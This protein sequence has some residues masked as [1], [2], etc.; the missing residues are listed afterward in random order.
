VTIITVGF[1]T[2]LSALLRSQADQYSPL[3]G[4]ELVQKKVN[5][6]VSMAG[7]FPS[8]GEYNI[9]EDVPAARYVYENFPTKILFSG[10]EIGD[11]IRSG[12]PLVTN[13]AIRNSPVKDVF[14][15]CTS[16][17]PGDK[18]GRQSWDQTAV[19]VAVRGY[20]PWYTVQEG[21]IV[22]EENGNNE[23]NSEARG[24]HHLVAK[25]SPADVAA[26][27]NDLMMHQ[28]LEPK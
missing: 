9:K 28:P 15:I 25:S 18:E 16:M 22:I 23:W 14:R 26:I 7:K 1:L 19:L 3:N 2:N 13:A 24:Q 11:N 17:V 12:I 27:I 21:R 6:L 5:R 20:E 10:F 4:R 8:G